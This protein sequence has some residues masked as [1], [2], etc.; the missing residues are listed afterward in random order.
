MVV[1]S[2]QINSL[3]NFT[4]TMHVL[5]FRGSE[6]E[7]LKSKVATE[8]NIFYCCSVSVKLEIIYKLTITYIS[9]QYAYLE[10]PTGRRAWWTAVH[11]VARSWTQLSN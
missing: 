1:W 8:L 10:N 9:L 7:G 5:L 11:G 3:N 2:L 6:K 4:L